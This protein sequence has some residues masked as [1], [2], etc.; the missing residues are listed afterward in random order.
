VPLPRS[1]AELNRRVPNHLMRPLAGRAPG[2]GIVLHTGRRSGKT[3]RT[4]VNVFRRPGGYTIALTYGRGDWV[5]NVLAAGRAQLVLRG[6]THEV[7]HPVVIEDP[8][9]D[10]LPLPVRT[11]LHAL[12]VTERLDVD[13]S[14]VPI[15]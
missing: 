10:D 6:K 8:S 15:A 14:R 9:H 11:I 1:I 3:Y 7:R 4:P 12:G 13:E 5:R 2:F